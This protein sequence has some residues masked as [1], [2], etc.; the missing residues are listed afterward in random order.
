MKKFFF[1]ALT[2]I[3]IMF[4]ACNS[5]DVTNTPS[6]GGGF[7][8][9][10][11]FEDTGEPEVRATPSTAIP[12]TSWS[13]IDK[14]RMFL[15]NSSDG[16]IA[17]SYEIDPAAKA[18]KVFNF[19]D[20]PSGTYDLALVANIKSSTNNVSTSVDGW[21]TLAEFGDYTVRTKRINTD[22][23]M[24][25]K[26]LG[27]FPTGHTVPAAR[28]PYAPASEVFMAYQSGIQIT[29]GATKDLTAT[30]LLLKREVS[31]MR[32]R[33]NKK[34][35][36][37]NESG[38]LVDFANATNLIAVQTIPVGFGV[39][40]GGFAGGI[41][42]TASNTDRVIVGASGASAFKTT[43]PSALTHTNPIVLDSDFTLWQD[44]LVLPNAT[45][46]EGKTATANASQD[47]KYTI[48]VSAQAPAGYKLD[49]GTVLSTARPIYWSGIINEVF[50]ENNIRE[51]NLTIKSRGT[52]VWPEIREVGGL[53]IKVSAPENWNT[54]I[55][56]TEKEI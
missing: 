16:K 4:S 28:L 50:L 5:D 12:I 1:S 26:K 33:I 31:M 49:N 38:K 52:D 20:I 21:A 30:P 32:V 43:N 46:A 6:D 47:R 48:I 44:V 45:K 42:T 8:F 34:A 13:N 10:V 25:L 55:Q 7:R 24:D 17:Y 37:L 23:V 11:D 27:S 41:N 56:S 35:D 39:K 3:A 9:S 2:A 51:V 22:V 14:I 53:D 18:D 29:T 40:L 54:T 36:F 15:Y 19:L